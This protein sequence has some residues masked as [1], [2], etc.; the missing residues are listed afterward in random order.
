MKYLDEIRALSKQNEEHMIFLRRQ[1]HRFPEIA[2]HEQE[3]AN[4]IRKELDRL[5]LD[6]R[7]IGTGTVTDIGNGTGKCIALRADIDALPITEETGDEFAS[8]NPGFMHACGHDCH[9]AMLLNTAAILSEM[10][11]KLPAPVRLI[12]QPAEEGGGGALSMIKGG[13]LDG[14]QS[15]CC[16]HMKAGTQSGVFATRPGL[17]HAASDGFIIRISGSKCHGSAPQCGVD[18]IVIAAHTVLALQE[19]ISREIGAFDN[20]V[21]T[22][23]RIHGGEARN[24]VCGEVTMDCT[25]R[26]LDESIRQRIIQ[27]IRD[28]VTATA[29][30][31]RGRAETEQVQSY[32]VCHNDETETDLAVSLAEEL[33]PEPVTLL[34]KPSMGGEDFGFYQQ[35]VPGVKM[36]MG[37]GCDEGLHTSRF[38]VDEKGLYRGAAL[39]AAVA[40]NRFA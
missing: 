21:L 5:G 35:I 28:I 32:C 37:T 18:A 3:T 7:K 20:A 39:L 13:V 16:L 17:I 14:V 12:F 33:F 1:L 6:Y 30:M 27:R 31:Y 15:I 11:D 25:L 19:I 38:R 29:Q 4:I 2:Y 36:Y 24:I 34:A 40:M 9:T 23:G 8:C 22:I 26:T 10:R